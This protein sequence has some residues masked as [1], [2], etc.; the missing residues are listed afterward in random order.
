MAGPSPKCLARLARP[1]SR[2][3]FGLVEGGQV[4]AMLPG[5][6]LS[7]HRR[8]RALPVL[9]YGPSR[10]A[11]TMR[12]A[13]GVVAAL[14]SW[15]AV[16]QPPK[17]S[18]GPQTITAEQARGAVELLD[19]R[20]EE[21]LNAMSL[22]SLDSATAKELAK[23]HG[24]LI[25]LDGLMRLDAATAAELANFRGDKLVLDGLTKLDVVTAEELAKCRCDTITL[26]HLTSL[27]TETAKALAEFRGD[28]I[29]LCGLPTLSA[30]A[31]NALVQFRGDLL[32][33]NGL[34]TLSAEV[35]SALAQFRG[36]KLM[37]I[38]VTS[39][40]AEAAKALASFGGEIWLDGLTTLSPEVAEALAKHKHKG[41]VTLF[42]LHTLPDKAAAALRANPNIRLK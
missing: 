5:E 8:F 6:M 31:A 7:E 32:V 10:G 29:N 14:L 23:F 37:L 28:E 3:D 9:S 30:E 17:T 25:M 42:G 18:D 27:S 1:D 22:R 19:S 38:G 24:K 35:A 13:L 2:S 21:V 39:L 16:A 36:D 20:G 33:L 4:T 15:A 34:T 40:S 12:Y 11:A 26:R 41:V